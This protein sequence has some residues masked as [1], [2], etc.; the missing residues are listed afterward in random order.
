MSTLAPQS[1]YFK[2]GLEWQWRTLDLCAGRKVD[3]KNPDYKFYMTRKTQQGKGRA[4]WNSWAAPHNFEGFFMNMGDML[5]KA[6]DWQT[7]IKIYQNAKLAQNYPS[8]LYRQMLEKRILNA[9]ANVVNF[10]KDN[11][12]PDK[13]ILFNSGYGCVACHQR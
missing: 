5:V 8:W 7:A 2:E 10:Q 1:D 11:P 9:K 6:G 4:C 3:R 12:D 13:A